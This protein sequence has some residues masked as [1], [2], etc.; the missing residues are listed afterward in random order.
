MKLVIY[1]DPKVSGKCMEIFGP[2]IFRIL[3]RWTAHVMFGW[4]IEA[5]KYEDKKRIN[6]VL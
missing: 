2:H 4:A 1:D 3:I 5:K 6:I